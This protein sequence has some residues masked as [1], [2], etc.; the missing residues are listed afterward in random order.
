MCGLGSCATSEITCEGDVLT[1][2]LESEGVRLATMD[3]AARGMTCSTVGTS[4]TCVGAGPACTA[5]S[6]RCEGTVA[7]TCVGGQETTEDCA[8]RLVEGTCVAGE[9]T[10]KCALGGACDPLQSTDSCVDDTVT[11]CAAGVERTAKCSDY[12]F[13]PCVDGRCQAYPSY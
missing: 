13:G 10:V 3:C 6:Q 9:V 4:A 11:F 8:A 2:C 12:G 1:Q 5:T 7:V